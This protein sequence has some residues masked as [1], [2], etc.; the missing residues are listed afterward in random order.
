MSL[1]RMEGFEESTTVADMISSGSGTIQSSTVRTGSQALQI[2]NATPV[3]SLPAAQEHATV[4]IGCGFLRSGANAEFRFSSDTN[5]TSHV[6]VTVRTAD[7]SIDVRRGTS[8]GTLLGSA[9]SAGTIPASAWVHLGIEVTLADSGGAVTIWKDGASIYTFS[10]DTKNAGTKTVFDTVSI[11][12]GNSCF[13]DDLFIYN[14]DATAPNSFPGDKKIITLMPNGDGATTQ[15]SLSTGSSHYQLVDEKPR[16]TTD[17]VFDT[18]TGHIDLFDFENLPAG[19]QNVSAIQIELYANKSDA[20]ATMKFAR[21]VRSGGTNYFGND[22]TL[23]TSFVYLTDN[24][25]KL[26]LA[27]DPATSAAWM[28]SAVDSVQVGVRLTTP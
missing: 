28:T 19:S 4:G 1:V 27:T 6:T 3:W 2:N 7:G 17:Y 13:I 26:V 20:G 22:I 25:Q 18:V 9:L 16:N 12:A 14:G 23:G 8:S 21:V 5:A 15:F 24:A 10:G 11:N